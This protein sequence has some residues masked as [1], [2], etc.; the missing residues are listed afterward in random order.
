MAA[1]SSLL[2]LNCFFTKARSSSYSKGCNNNTHRNFRVIKAQKYH[3]EGRSTNMVDANLNVLKER[4]EMVKEKEKLERCCKCQQGWNY[5]PVSDDHLLL[6]CQKNKR[7]SNNNQELLQN[8]IELTCLVCGT[9]GSTC[10]CGTLFLCLVSFLLH[11]Q[12]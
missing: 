2:P 7:S 12:L 6:H 10:F 11:L 3:E 4:I 5:Y 9:I 8:L 1:S